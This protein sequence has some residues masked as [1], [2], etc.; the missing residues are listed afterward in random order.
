MEHLLAGHAT[1][2]GSHGLFLPTTWRLAPPL[3]AAT[4]ELFYESRLSPAA[5]VDGVRLVKAGRFSGAG[6]WIVDSPHDGNRDAS[7]EEAD[8]VVRLVEEILAH[9]AN[10]VDLHGDTHGVVDTDILVVAP[11]NAHVNRVETRL[12]AAGRQTRVGTVDKFQGQEAPI[13]IYT[14]ASS[15]PDDAPRGLDF[16]YNASRLN[17]ATSRARAAAIL[18]ASPA[19]F[20]PECRTPGQMKLANALC[21]IREIATSYAGG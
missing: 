15:S 4:S 11:Y 5:G 14:M 16:L 21:R 1:M 19:L 12:R 2:P 17:V 3:C 9:G 6:L 13:V 10:W 8:T 18:V 20:A 7:D